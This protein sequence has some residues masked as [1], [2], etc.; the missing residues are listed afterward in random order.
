MQTTIVIIIPLLLSIAMG[1][2]RPRKQ[3]QPAVAPAH[4]TTAE[5]QLPYY[6]GLIEEYKNILAEDP[7]NLAGLIALAHA[8]AGSNQWDK[9]IT[10][11]EH[12]LRIDPHNADLH[13]DLGIA[14]RSAGQSDRA[15]REFRKAIQ[16]DPVHQNARFHMGIAYAYDKKDYPAAIRI[17]EELLRISPHHAESEYM[18]HCI[19]KF[20]E[21]ARKVSR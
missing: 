1:C 20:G 8:Y 11:Y 9:A 15:L 17:W 13:A 12:A 6:L 3:A 5:Q 21:M 18:R 2:D 7:N 10:L 4:R 16:I 14:C 19:V